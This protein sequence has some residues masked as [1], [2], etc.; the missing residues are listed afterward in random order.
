[1][2]ELSRIQPSFLRNGRVSRGSRSRLTPKQTES[3]SGD[4]LFDRIGRAVCR[5]GTLPAKELF[6]AWETARRVR[7]KYR[8]RRVLDLA[9]G[10]GLLAHLMLILDDTSPVAV[11]VDAESFRK[12]TDPFQ[13]PHRDTWPRLSERIHYQT[14]RYRI[15]F[16]TPRRPGG[17]GPCLRHPHRP[18]PGQG[19]RGRRRRGG[20]SLL[21]RC[22]PFRHRVAH[23]LDGRSPWPWT[24]CGP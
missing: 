4:T 5:A 20:P 12:R 18:H 11:A 1:M 13:S 7:R 3:F 15:G 10:H 22:R 19:H 16:G 23:R 2:S 14:G 9:C 17:L 24:P 8:G 21:P 6:E